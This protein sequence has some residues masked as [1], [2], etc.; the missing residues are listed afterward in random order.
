MYQQPCKRCRL[1]R[2]E[3]VLNI[4]MIFKPLFMANETTGLK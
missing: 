1:R 3:L 4:Y 2:D